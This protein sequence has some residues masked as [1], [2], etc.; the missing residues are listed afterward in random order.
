MD[1]LARAYFQN[2]YF[3][4]TPADGLARLNR[5]V[6]RSSLI[7]LMSMA[8]QVSRKTFST[9]LSMVGLMSITSISILM[10]MAGLIFKIPLDLSR[11][12]QNVF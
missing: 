10:S 2:S 7:Y 12:V 5:M 1:G 6:V 8:G 9:L 4:I 11:K 3:G